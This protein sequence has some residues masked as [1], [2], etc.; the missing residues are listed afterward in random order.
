MNNERTKLI[1]RVKKLLAMA[2]DVGSPEE[3]VIAARRARSMMDKYDID[4]Q[5]VEQFS[6]KSKFGQV[7]N[8]KAYKYTP[9][10]MQFLSH[11][12]ARWNDCQATLTRE[13]ASWNSAGQLYSEN[14]TITFRGLEADAI[15]AKCMFEY[16]RDIVIRLAKQ[17]GYGSNAKQLTS[18]KLGA[19]LELNRRI[20]ALI[21]QRT[22]EYKTSTGTGLVVIK[23]QLVDAE[24]GKQKFK[25][26]TPN[27]NS[28]S[29]A[30]DGQREGAKI[31]LHTQLNSDGGNQGRLS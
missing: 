12:V 9:Q 26:V 8:D 14:N 23:K 2:N 31:N 5:E 25:I 16:L 29:A 10:W 7:Q 28:H 21:A 30:R 15:M 4:Q 18:F 24:F 19:T 13:G 11:T 17:Q 1:E 20:N 22:E 6:N 3:A 27:I